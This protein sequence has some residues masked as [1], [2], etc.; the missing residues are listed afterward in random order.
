MTRKDN[1][2]FIDLSAA[3]KKVAEAHQGVSD[4]IL[5]HAEKHHAEREENRTRLGLERGLSSGDG[6][7][8]PSV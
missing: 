7:P 2:A 6:K 5:A 1:T 8:Y 4:S 3:M